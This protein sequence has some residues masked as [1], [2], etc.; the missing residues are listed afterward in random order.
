MKTSSKVIAI[1]IVLTFFAALFY[2]V[3]TLVDCA[4]AGL[5]GGF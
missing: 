2:A 4:N 3:H 1:V 5:H